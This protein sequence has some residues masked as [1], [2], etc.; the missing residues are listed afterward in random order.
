MDSTNIDN[1]DRAILRSLQN[2]GR[3][4][5]AA[6]AQQNNLSESACRRRVERLEQEKFIIGYNAEIDA[7]KLGLSLNVF[8]S[9]SLNAQTDKD[10]TSFERMV[11]NQPEI[12]ECWL[13]TGQDDYLLKIGARG[14]ED[15]ERIHR[16]VL[17]KLP[18]VARINT[19]IAMRGVKRAKAVS[20]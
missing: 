5:I 2:D 8:V 10:L 14:I 6:L 4:T 18:N 16:E 7:Q 19:A 9:I 1:K 12:L 13:M 3:I 17:T 15:L 20:I 11:S